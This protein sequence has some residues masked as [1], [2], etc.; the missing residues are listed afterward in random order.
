MHIHNNTGHL[1]ESGFKMLVV[2]LPVSFMMPGLPRFVLR[3][4]SG[5]C[6]TVITSNELSRHNIASSVG[7][8]SEWSRAAEATYGPR[9]AAKYLTAKAM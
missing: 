3:V 6:M 4:L 1:V 7:S 8:Q 2:T 5:S 9:S